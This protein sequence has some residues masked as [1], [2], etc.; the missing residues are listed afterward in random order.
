MRLSLVALAAAAVSVQAFK[1]TSPFILFSNSPLPSS[2]QDVSTGQLQSKT[3]VLSSAKKFLD[4]CQSQIYYIISQPSISLSDLSTSAPHLKSALSNPGVQSRFSVGE[5]VGLN[6]SDADEIEAY[7]QS[8]CGAK[9][10]DYSGGDVKA[11]LG[12]RTGTGGS[13]VVVKVKQAAIEGEDRAEGVADADSAL[14]PLLSELPKGYKYTLIYITTPSTAP[15]VPDH[16]ELVRYESSFDEVLHMDLKRNLQ[17]RKDDGPTPDQ[18]PL[19][20]KYQFFN[21]G[22]FMGL[23][24]ALLLL[25]ILGVGFSALGSLQ[26]SYGAFD[27]EMGPAAQ[28][29]QQ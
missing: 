21:P 11:A 8:R 18:R 7:I 14:Y 17:A 20:E 5:V 6:A 10:A 9:K 1:D 27:K 2:F 12:Q 24:V 13:S 28:K 16:T 25:S 3:Q 15:A 19:F 23:L 4:G 22:L 29:K 26:V